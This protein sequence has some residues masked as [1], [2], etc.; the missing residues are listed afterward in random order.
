M[1]AE[2]PK[3]MMITAGQLSVGGV[4]NH[5]L[6]LVEGLRDRFYFSLLGDL[7]EPFRSQWKELGQRIYLYSPRGSFD[8]AAWRETRRVF[9][10]EKP[11]LIHIHDSR[12]GFLA[13]LA[14]IGRCVPVVYSMHYP[15]YE[16]VDVSFLK[17]FFYREIERALNWLLT[18]RIVFLFRNV[19]ADAVSRLLAP[20]KRAIVIRTGIEVERFIRASQARKTRLANDAEATRLIVVA[21]LTHQ[22]RVELAIQ[23]AALLRT[24]GYPVSLTIVGDGPEWQDQQ[25]EALRL[26]ISG[27]V[28]FL[29]FRDDV[30]D[31][32]AMSDVFLL[33]SRY[34][35]G[36]YVVMEAMAAGK[37][38]VATAVGDV[39]WLLADRAGI[40]VV[41]PKPEMFA[42]AVAELIE[43]DDLRREMGNRAQQKAIAEF[44][45]ERMI[46]NYGQL[47]Q[48]I[49]G[50]KQ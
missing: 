1:M 40:I 47:Y 12:A 35:G 31:L 28:D 27:Q 17:R 34:E 3:I 38:C 42:A 50:G 36:P 14:N 43:N 5:L 25:D 15:S 20:R 48:S 24:Q 18:D 16:Y 8:L 44:S 49:L 10:Q 30:S 2:Y 23:A 6:S 39:P 13:R 32:L 4:E 9:R 45:L 26:G 41:E 29:G 11:D 7:K 19:H 33:T 46:A 22:K 37:P 21:R